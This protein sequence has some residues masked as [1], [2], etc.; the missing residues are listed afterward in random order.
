[1]PRI[2]QDVQRALQLKHRREARRKS[3]RPSSPLRST[4][5]PDPSV[6]PTMSTSTHSALSTTLASSK[7]PSNPTTPTTALATSVLTAPSTAEIDFAP[8][9]GVGASPRRR[10]LLHP[11]PISVDGGETLDWSGTGYELVDEDKDKDKLKEKGEKEKSEKRWSLIK[12]S[13]IKTVSS[14]STNKKVIITADQIGRRYNL[15]YASSSPSAS[16]S[17]GSAPVLNPPTSTFNLLKV[18]KWYA[19]QDDIV[20]ASLESA[21]PFVWLKHL[22]KNAKDETDTTTATAPSRPP[23]HLSALIMEEYIHAQN[24][25]DQI[26]SNV[27]LSEQFPSATTWSMG[28]IP[29]HP[30]PTTGTSSPSYPDEGGQ[31]QTPFIIP[32]GYATPSAYSAYSAYSPPSIYSNS[33]YSPPSTYSAPSAPYSPNPNINSAH[34]PHLPR[35][36]NLHNLSN[37]NNPYFPDPNS[38]GRISFEPLL[39]ELSSTSTPASASTSTAQEPPHPAHT[40]HPPRSL[41]SIRVR[42]KGSLPTKESLAIEMKRRQEITE[43]QEAEEAR[44]D[45]EYE[46]KAQWVD[47]EN[48]HSDPH[49]RIAHN[50]KS[51]SA[52]K[53]EYNDQDSTQVSGSKPPFPTNPLILP[54][55]LLEAFSHDPANV[56][57][58]TKRLKSYRAVDDIHNRLTKQREVF[59]QFLDR[60]R[61]LGDKTSHLEEDILKSPIDALLRTLKDVEEHRLRVVDKEKEV[62]EMLKETQVVH[63]EVKKEYN[64]TL[65]HTSVVYPELSQITALEESYKD[66][67]QHLWD[68]GMSFLTFLLDTI[69][70][71]WRTYGKV[72]GDDV[73]D[74]L[75]VPIYRHEFTGEP[76]RYLLT[77]IP[78]R[79]VRHWVGLGMV[80]MCTL[81]TVV[82]QGRIALGSVRGGNWRLQVLDRWMNDIGLGS[83]AGGW[84]KWVR[85]GMVMPFWWM[86]ILGQWGA[87][88]GELVMVLMQV[89]MMLWWI[90]WSIGVVD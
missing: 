9:T 32:S 34:P 70:P 66:E 5:F 43:K 63:A 72:I 22:E 62:S 30:S 8:S 85:W 56:T 48:R 11:I 39:T 75:I 78:K 84:G 76:K 55:L 44:E 14:Q 45:M 21:E 2:L 12:L 89:G 83:R 4:A 10:R 88:I 60:N 80:F 13:R 42:N 46:L 51:A 38:S 28:P 19:T 73:Q 31:S 54:P 16:S 18:S 77:R 37:P 17:F 29:E 47:H 79:S 90:G 81:G 36:Q 69:T 40:L 1:D 64:N 15:I 41:R 20:R 53:P 50:R 71:F 33:T 6:V 27:Q 26:T 68:L 67:Y 35:P 65:A 3:D 86:I 24:A 61:N 82:V 74:L 58:S 59:R 7:A 23:W 52:R 87:V 49:N 25:K 57:S